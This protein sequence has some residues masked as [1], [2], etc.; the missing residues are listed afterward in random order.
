MTRDALLSMLMY[1]VIPIWFIAGIADWLCHRATR[2]EHTSGPKE[3]LIH[4]LMFAQVGLPLA[5][6]LMFEINA[7][8]IAL[9]IVM[10]LLHQAT[11]LWDVSYSVKLR[12]IPPIEQHVHSFLEMLPLMAMLMVFAMH[13]GQFLALF[14]QGDEAPRFVLELKDD[15]LPLHYVVGVLVAAALIEFAP[16][17]EEL[18]RGLRARARVGNRRTDAPRP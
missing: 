6:A 13:W 2:I 8:L 3:S 16:F 7:L 17:V 9:F 14:G 11:A 15:P 5:A 10:F 12:P 1:F 18:I 4:L